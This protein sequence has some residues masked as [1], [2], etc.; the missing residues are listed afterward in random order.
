MTE[1]TEQQVREALSTV[2]V[3]GSGETL[4]ALGMISG[5]VIKDRNVQ[6]SIE[7]DPARADEMETVRKAA[8]TAVNAVPN[9][10]SVTAILTAESKAGE[11]ARPSV[12]EAGAP[13][14]PGRKSGPAGIAN[15]I[16]VASGKGGVGKSTTAVNLA[17]SLKQLGL[18][19]G[20]LDADVFGP[21]QPR[22]LGISGRPES[23]AFATAC[24][25]GL[26]SGAGRGLRPRQ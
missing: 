9:V 4:V 23:A 8:E 11:A 3:P 5:M 13:P 7:I 15:I 19:V 18:K 22:M 24:D 16:A 26:A 17:L 1:V 2:V 6:F 21:S 20:M 12:P 14:R 10:L 25:K